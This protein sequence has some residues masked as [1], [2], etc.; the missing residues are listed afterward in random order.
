MRNPTIPGRL[1][2]ATQE[3][4]PTASRLRGAAQEHNPTIPGRLGG[5]TQEHNP[6]ITINHKIVGL[7]SIYDFADIDP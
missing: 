1:G 3:H 6:T 2:G 4:N 7:R 5:A